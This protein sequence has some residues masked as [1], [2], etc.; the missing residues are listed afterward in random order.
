VVKYLADIFNHGAQYRDKYALLTSHKKIPAEKSGGAQMELINVEKK[1]Y[2]QKSDVQFTSTTM[3]L[4]KRTI[5][6]YIFF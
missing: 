5:C 6:K 1:V 3:N 4:Y 2:V